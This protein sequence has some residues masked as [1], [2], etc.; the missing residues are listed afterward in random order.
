MNMKIISQSKVTLFARLPENLTQSHQPMKTTVKFLALARLNLAVLLL[1]LTALPAFAGTATWGGLGADANWATGANWSGGSAS[2]AAAAGDTLSFAGT[3]RTSPVNNMTA[4]TSFAG[5]NFPNT[6]AG[7]TFT[8]S[9][10]RITLSGNI[11]SAAGAIADSSSIPMI[12]NGDR[13]ITLNTSHNLTLSGI[14]SDDGGTRALFKDGAGTLTLSGNNSF[15][16]NFT[17]L[18][19][20]VNVTNF[21]ASGS[22]SPVGAGSAITLATYNSSYQAYLNYTGTGSGSMTNS[23]TLA[24]NISTA[25]A[26][27]QNNGSGPLVFNGPFV[28]TSSAAS[29]GLNL[30][31]S[32]AGANDFQCCI[33]DTPASTLTVQVWNGANWTLSC[34]TNAYRNITKVSW[35]TLNV[36]TIANSGVA[37]SMGTAL[38]FQLGNGANS[39]IFNYT[40]VGNTNN[41]VAYVGSSGANTGG[42]VIRNN[43]SGPLVFTASPF[44][45]AQSGATVTNPLTL[46]GNYTGAANQIQ[47]IIKD[48][49][50]TGPL[51]LAKV[52]AGTW[53]LSGTNTYSGSTIVSNG[54]LLVNS[55]GSLTNSSAVTVDGT[56]GGT[57]G[58]SGIINGTV[59]VQNNGVIAPSQFG[60]SVSTLTLA[61][62]TAPTFNAGSQLK[63]R[64]PTGSTADQIAL[65]SATPVFDPANLD[66]TLDTTG[67]RNNATNLTIVSAAKVSG[68]ISGNPFH[69]TN[70]VGNT[71]Y[72]ATVHY[73]TALG[74]ITVDLTSTYAGAPPTL[75]AS[76]SPAATTHFGAVT[77]TATAT[78]GGSPISSVTLNAAPI[79]GS[80]ALALVSAGGNVY[81]NTVVVGGVAP[82][83]TNTLTVTALDPYLSA[84]TNVYLTVIATNRIWNGA[85]LASANWSDTTNWVG[86]VGPGTGDGVIF[87]GTT[88]LSPVMDGNYSVAS[89]TFDPTAGGFTLGTGSS[90]LTLAGGGVTNNSANLQTINTPVVLVGT[91]IFNTA[92]NNIV[93]QQVVSGTNGSLTATGNGNL[94]IVAQATYKG[95]T[96]ING[97]SLTVDSKIHT[98]GGGPVTINSGGVLILP[99]G[100][101]GFGWGGS[102]GQIAVNGPGLII[103]G[104]TISQSGFG[105]PQTVGGAGR[106]FTIGA[107][108]ATLESAYPGQTFS[109]GFRYD[110][111]P[112]LTSTAG[113]N[114][115]LTGIGNGVLDY[116][117]PGT[118]GLIKNGSGTWTLTQ[119]NTYTGITMVNGGTLEFVNPAFARTSTVL[120]T[121]GATLQLDQA[122]TNIVAGLVLNG[123]SQAPGLY[124][125]ATGAPYITGSG[126]LLVT[127]PGPFNYY[128][129][130]VGGNDANT[131]ISISQAWQSL[132]NVNANAFGPGDNILFKAG[133]TWSGQLH[134]LGSGNTNGQVTIDRYGSG[135]KPV[136]SG[137]GISGGAVYLQNQQYWSINNLDVNNSGSGT[138]NPVKQGI[139]IE[140]DSAGT[141]NSIYV[142][143][144]Y[145]HDVSGVMTNYM[146]SKMSG[147]IV[148]NIKASNTNVPS[149][150]HDVRIVNNVITNVASQG[151]LLRS[152]YI[153]KPWDPVLNYGAGYGIYYPSTN[154]LIANN[155]LGSI[156]G[157]GI[158]TW[159]CHGALVQSNYCQQANNNTL[160]QGHVAIWPYISENCVFQYNEVCQT[161]TKVDGMAFDFDAGNQNCIYQYNYSHDNQGGFL[162]MCSTANANGNIARYNISQNDGCLAGSRVFTIAQPGNHN[163]SVYNN[164]I[165]VSSNNPVVF[166]DDGGGSSNSLIYFYNNIFINQGT[167]SVTTPAGCVFD[168]NLYY[169]NG[170]IASDTHKIL[171]NP[172]LVSAGS[173]TYGL[174]SVAGYKLTSGSPAIGAGVLIA[175]NGGLDYWGNAVSSVTNPDMGA[176]NAL[177]G[178]SVNTTPTN[179][180]YSVSGSGSSMSLNLSWPTDHIGWR[181]L[182]QTNNLSKGVSGNTNDWATYA[183][184]YQTTNKVSIPIVQTTR[185]EFYRLV[186]P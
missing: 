55:P 158:V 41:R 131:G 69:S 176:D 43:G 77:I 49:S 177:T 32:Y 23:R 35:G 104:G 5:I 172:Q 62:A 145:I 169:G 93:L 97:G 1:V 16:G 80:S 129:D 135:A 127:G 66:L 160:G 17:I 130:S 116:V 134:P 174:G 86:N 12:L 91:E 157:D 78:P 182:V 11:V 92:S 84:S 106:Q 10:N 107:L 137:G 140:N 79:G 25:T 85:S 44:I 64:V 146:D 126:A 118:G 121:N 141:L 125:S 112:V 117:L 82:I 133:D 52:D 167:G 156:A 109:I 166:Q 37:C 87:A 34:P 19:G 2:G 72:V 59:T 46:G 13:T 48:N 155:V 96:T 128:V 45:V 111:A 100:A 57:L 183:G 180:L 89:I 36:S 61:N 99:S 50:A 164:T 159:C 20:Q 143:N 42:G 54:T 51:R 153:S 105:N 63:I 108:G 68:G 119:T 114:L 4:D 24:L 173:G 18:G 142:S 31:G 124:D 162:N 83:G 178:P 132:T 165:Y 7:Q 163:N 88:Q 81:T 28:N 94:E 170:S 76:L 27:I 102:L 74:T 3:T 9:G 110:Y 53:I 21:T 71:F 58:G 47:G 101:I 113:G 179:I 138:N 175:N 70:I 122:I 6:T 22:S 38:Q 29:P 75:T 151:I 147:G 60:G 26:W 90:T 98:Q 65:S 139:Y 185:N 103:N 30:A 148:F 144:C 168:Y 136:I 152:L 184:G 123:V 186:Y 149:N 181:L 154:V 171:S 40:G 95:T 56:A 8:L 120:I 73:N 161:Q 14:L 15:G 67:L 115:T 150:W 39:G 33:T